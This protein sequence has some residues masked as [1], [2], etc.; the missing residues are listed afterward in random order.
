MVLV[1]FPL[2]TSVVGGLFAAYLGV[3]A[4][5]SARRTGSR[6]GWIEWAAFPLAV[7]LAIF[8]MTLGLQGLS[9][10]DGLVAGAPYPPGLVFAA[11]AALA[12]VY[13]FRVIL[14]GGASGT[15]RVARHAWRMILALFVAA[16]SLFL[17]Q[18]EVVPPSIRNSPWLLAPEIAILAALVIWTVKLCAWPRRQAVFWPSRRRP[19][20]T[21]GWSLR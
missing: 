14:V 1:L 6:A 2:W 10:P 17:G 13:D 18:T 3:T 21:E 19:T 11:L 9:S 12:A 8:S 5:A 15:P 20:L 4:W 7:T 16:G